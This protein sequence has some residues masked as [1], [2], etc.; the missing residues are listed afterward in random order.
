MRC[1]AM[2]WGPGFATR[3]P[4]YGYGAMRVP[5]DVFGGAAQK[6]PESAVRSEK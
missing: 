3:G 1:P 6:E 2:G 5:D 4:H